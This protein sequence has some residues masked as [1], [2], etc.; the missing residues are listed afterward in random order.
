S[1]L[2]RPVEARCRALGERFRFFHVDDMSGGKAGALNFAL[3]HTVDDA[4]L[5]ASIDADYQAEP[6]FLDRLVGHFDDPAVG[7]V[8]TKHHYRDWK[9]SPYQRMCNWEYQYPLHLSFPSK[10]ERDAAFCIGTMC[11]LRREALEEVGGWAEWCVTEDWEVTI[12]IHASGYSSIYLCDTAG[13]GLIPESFKGY[14][15]QRFRWTYGPT[16]GLKRHLRLF[17]PGRL[18]RASKMTLA[19][20]V[21]H[22]THMLQQISSGLSFLFLPL[23]IL[24]AIS[25]LVHKEIVPLPLVVWVTLP[26]VLLAGL[27]HTYLLHGVVLRCSLREAVGAIAASMALGYTKAIAGLWGLF[28]RT[29]PWRRTSKFKELPLGLEAVRAALPETA[30]AVTAALCAIGVLLLLP[31]WSPHLLFLVAIGLFAKSFGYAAAPVLALI[32]DRSVRVATRP[33]AIPT[34][35][36]GYSLRLSV[37]VPVLNEERT[38][39]RV[40]EQLLATPVVS[41]VIVVDDG[42][43]DRTREVVAPFQDRVKLLS[44]PENRGKG[45]AIRTGLAKVTGNAVVIQDGDLEYDPKDLAGMFQR[46]EE[47]AGVVYGSRILGENT[48]AHRSFYLGGRLLTWL[49]NLLY[50]L[51]I[52]DEATCYKM[53]RTDVIDRLDLQC[54]GFEF[55]PEV[56]AKLGRLGQEIVEVPISYASRTVA[57]GKK[58][59]WWHGVEAIATLLRYRFWRPLEVAPE[60]VG[61]RP[62]VPVSVPVTSGAEAL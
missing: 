10:N 46:L 23:G 20:K 8:Q 11:L 17:L 6:D 44:H 1:A 53:I 56:T 5:I 16:Q 25:M 62:L 27:A 60:A 13:R 31:A 38:L 39:P 51:S 34:H 50:G 19:Q 15:Q 41:E 48:F 2:W 45:A 7:L 52:T 24:V 57:M 40:L 30:L 12:R 4:E 61:T 33:R 37:I 42:S 43:T 49:A 59:R 28:T 55:C 58:I 47:G 36:R 3:R 32:A 22:L 18:G 54:Q 26:I 9:G 21:H 35:G 29:I 14:K